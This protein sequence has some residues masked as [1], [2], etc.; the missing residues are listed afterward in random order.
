MSIVL[1]QI[2]KHSVSSYWYHGQAT[3]NLSY[4]KEH[5]WL[6]AQVLLFGLISTQF[7]QPQSVA[8]LSLIASLVSAN[9]LST[10]KPDTDTTVSSWYKQYHQAKV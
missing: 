2:S 6:W 7:Q 10:L 3:N 5:S 4:V 8:V 9:L 1:I